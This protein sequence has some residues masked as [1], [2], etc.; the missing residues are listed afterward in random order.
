[1]P[2]PWL[3]EIS[4]QEEERVLG[5]V[6]TAAITCNANL[7]RMFADEARIEPALKPLRWAC[8]AAACYIFRAAL[9]TAD[10]KRVESDKTLRK[11]LAGVIM[12][13]ALVE[14]ATAPRMICSEA[15]STVVPV[16]W[17][18]QDLSL[19]GPPQEEQISCCF[20]VESIARDSVKKSHQ[21][22]W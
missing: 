10:D 18:A 2:S 17:E 22:V 6:N 3:N 15:L 12:S 14:S 16:A 8:L 21:K 20:E 19:I 5:L 1:L 13:A 4:H 11:I 7:R 9:Y